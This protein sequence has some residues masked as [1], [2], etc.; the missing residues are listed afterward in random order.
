M[1]VVLSLKAASIWNNHRAAVYL[2]NDTHIQPVSSVSFLMT[3]RRGSL[4]MFD[5]RGRQMVN[6]SVIYVTSVAIIAEKKTGLLTHIFT[7]GRSKP[8]IC[9]LQIDAFTPC[10]HLAT[11]RVRFQSVLNAS[12]MHLH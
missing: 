9:V 10:Q 12:C 5:K 11:V 7:L 4:L 8:Y 1:A 2:K 6:F 3:E